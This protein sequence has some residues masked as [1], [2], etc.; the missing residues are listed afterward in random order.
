MSLKDLYKNES[1][2]LPAIPS[3]TD[4]RNPFLVNNVET[5]LESALQL[6]GTLSQLEGNRLIAAK[7]SMKQGEYDPREDFNWYAS[8]QVETT[9]F[10]GQH[11]AIWK[12]QIVGSGD[13][14]LE[15]ER[16]AKY[17]CG[18]DCRPVVV[19]ILNDEE[20]TEKRLSEEL[21]KIL[22]DLDSGKVNMVIETASEFI[23][24]M[25]KDLTSESDE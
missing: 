1:R 21:L 6:L 3:L 25:N 14:R 20:S 12:K 13:T 4:Q 11:I 2:P 17:Y 18:D 23:S 10:K 15:A 7:G 8:G 19:Y 5:Y 9:S 16:I 22:D 24:N